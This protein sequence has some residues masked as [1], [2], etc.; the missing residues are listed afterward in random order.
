MILFLIKDNNMTSGYV[1]TDQADTHLEQA[2]STIAVVV[3]SG[4]SYGTSSGR[5]NNVLVTSNDKH[6]KDEL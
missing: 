1:A 5:K 3:T 6:Y 4:E 2:A